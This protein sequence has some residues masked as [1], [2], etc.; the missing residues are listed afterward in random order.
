MQVTTLGT[1][2]W[3]AELNSSAFLVEFDDSHILFDC[4]KGATEGVQRAGTSLADVSHLFFTHHHWDH[5]MDV[6]HFVGAGWQLGR[7]APLEVYGPH[8]IGD[9][10]GTEAFLEGLFGRR[11]L[12]A[13]DIANRLWGQAGSLAP[14][15]ILV[16]G[17]DIREAG[18][19][20]EIGGAQISAISVVH[21][22]DIP[23]FAFR[24]D[25]PS[26]SVVITGDTVKLDSVVAFAKAAD[27]LIHD[28]TGTHDWLKQY[29]EEFNDGVWYHSSARQVGEVAAAA[30]VKKVVAAH[31][32]P[33]LVNEEGHSAIRAEIAESFGGEIFVAADGLT[34]RS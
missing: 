5:N 31:L 8:G 27:I 21:M 30:R 15:G 3:G 17:H 22:E 16:H 19:V 4:G 18:H 9:Y 13:M 33:P 26:G 23:S 10:P 34:I 7:A 25:A 12:W 28:C 24:I 1:T 6:V 20:C 14:E 2:W 11:G 29:G 32:A